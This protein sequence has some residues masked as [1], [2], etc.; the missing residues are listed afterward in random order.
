[1]DIAG[2]KKKIQRAKKV[3]EETY[4][5]MNELMERMQKLQEDLETT[6]HQVDNIESELAEQRVL[7]EALA[8]GQGVDV[9]TLLAEADLPDPSGT[10]GQH[11]QAD[12]ESDE[13]VS[14]LA[15]SRPSVTGDSE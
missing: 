3:T 10:D 15:T 5:K 9:E 8:E 7:L 14:P 12:D 6:S 13:D 4:K 11:A 1:M 2:T